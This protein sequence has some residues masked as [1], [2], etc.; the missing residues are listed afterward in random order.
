M[1]FKQF[2]KLME[3]RADNIVKNAN[4]VKKQVATV[5]VETLAYTTPVDEGVAVSN[6][7]VGVN[8]PRTETI[9]AH[10]PGVSRSTRPENIRATIGNAKAII[11]TVMPGD[12]VHVSN[13][14][15]YIF[16]LNRGTSG[17]APNG[18]TKQSIAKAK[19]IIKGAKLL[20]KP[21]GRST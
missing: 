10:N 8:E 12:V 2:A 6:W 17:Q 5:L 11:D 14:V 7:L 16:D 4:N 18:M 21:N 9:P 19:T 3:Q 15:P 13:S 1:D 20:G